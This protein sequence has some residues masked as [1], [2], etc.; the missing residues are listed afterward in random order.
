[1][2]Q[3]PWTLQRFCQTLKTCIAERDLLTGKSLQ[4]LYAKSLISPSTYLD[5]HFILLYSKCGRL[6]S[7]R[8]AFDAAPH[9]NVF[10]FNAIIAAYAKE[11]QPHVAHQL[12]DKNPQPDLVSYNTLISAYADRGDTGPALRLFRGMRDEDLDMD[13]F[14]F[15]AVITACSRDI[16]LISQL[17]ALAFLGGFDSYTSVNNT[18]ITYYGKNGFLEEAKRVFYGMGVKQDEVSWNSMIVAY[19][20]HREGAKALAL[21]QEMVHR[22]L[23]VD[24]FTLASVLTAFTCLQDLC[25]GIQFHAQLIKTGFNQNSHVGSGLI[26][27][28]SKCRGGMSDCRKV[29]QEI[30]EPDLVLWNTMISGYSQNEDFSEEALH[31]FAQMLRFGYRPDDCSF[32]LNTITIHLFSAN[33]AKNWSPSFFRDME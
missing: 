2:N 6:T 5:N 22:E 31:C 20:Q 11:S 29:F 26:D 7:A 24:M 14:T 9:P 4:A 33:T 25:G 3:I 32:V 16:V 15:S 28:Y 17:H 10:T 12:F 13:G 23:Y 27:L 19:G 8:K 1:M 21:Y 18:L 30:S